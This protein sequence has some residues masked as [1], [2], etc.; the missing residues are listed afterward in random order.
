MACCM[1]GD[2][3]LLLKKPRP[4]I[5]D[6]YRKD[7][8]FIMQYDFGCYLMKLHVKCLIGKQL[9][10]NPE[11]EIHLIV[12]RKDESINVTKLIFKYNKI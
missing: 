2:N 4:L 6:L 9:V 8:L 11:S 3:K 10:V 12:F 1:T 5:P 7:L